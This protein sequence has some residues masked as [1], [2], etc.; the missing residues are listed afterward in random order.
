M[1]TDLDKINKF[2]SQITKTG[3][4]DALKNL[5][6]LS[7]ETTKSLL[8]VIDKFQ[9][10]YNP[11]DSIWVECELIRRFLNPSS[12]IEKTIEKVQGP[13]SV[14][15]L[16]HKKY[17]QIFYLFG[18]HHFSKE[19]ACPKEN[20]ISQYIKDTITN[21]PVFIDV[22]IEENYLHSDLIT[23][24]Y[25]S[26]SSG[27][28]VDYRD[29]IVDMFGNCFSRNKEFIPFSKNKE[30][31]SC[32]TSRFH[33]SDPRNSF[34]TKSQ[35]IGSI[36]INSL[37]PGG[38]LRGGYTQKELLGITDY[39]DFIK[40]DNSLIHKRIKKQIKNIEDSTI[41]KIIKELYVKNCVG[42]MAHIQLPGRDSSDEDVEKF[43]RDV[44]N[45]P[46]IKYRNCIVDY[47]LISRCFRKY[48]KKKGY[49][50][51]SYN[52]IIYAGNYH[53]RIYVSILQT[54]GFTIKYKNINV[55]KN[56]KRMRNKYQCIDI[57]KMK[58]PMFYQRY[59]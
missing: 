51:P 16:S 2:C 4:P 13:V 15:E 20:M 46:D 34:E 35:L 6:G 54:L 23:F 7:K 9:R 10:K 53:I 50:R 29:E 28:P 36:L 1:V 25:K 45:N 14:Y 41:R 32:Q 47:Y 57:G 31:I 24:D 26:M 19:S 3:Y 39:I 42:Q 44:L 21:S 33:Y 43:I 17:P 59:K 49:S 58:Q 5:K 8:R 52:N 30:F 12:F 55:N 22:H 37:T 40:N 56:N 18:D 48:D 27:N 38:F 11:N